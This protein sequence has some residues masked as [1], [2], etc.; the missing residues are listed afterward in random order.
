[1]A[2]LGKDV[3]TALLVVLMIMLG[4]A[5]AAEVKAASPSPTLEAGAASMA[6]V[7][8]AFAAFIVSFIP[9]LACRFY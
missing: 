9:F 2:G 1:M 3:S 4:A 7:P 6:F 5:E 8:S